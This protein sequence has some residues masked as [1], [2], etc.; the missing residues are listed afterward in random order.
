MIELDWGEYK[1]PT[2]EEA[3]FGP[4]GVRGLEIGGGPHARRLRCRQ[5]DAIDWSERTGL[6]YDIG[7]ARC[8]PYEDGSFEY[9]YV[10]NLLEHFP[11]QETTNVL[12]E[13]AR[14][15][16]PEGVLELVVPDSIAL[17]RLY[18]WS[19]ITWDECAELLRG[20]ED[21]DGNRHYAAFTLSEFPQ[22][23]ER[24]ET[25]RL[26]S[27]EPSFGGRGVYALCERR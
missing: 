2:P 21:Y 17:L 7:D 15:L 12:T 20:S 3:S 4:F 1:V 27:C 5:F 25:L 13:W 26:V 10:A 8:L 11:H 19:E 18:F 9:I 14:V 22:V 24:V 16:T 23:I 6:T